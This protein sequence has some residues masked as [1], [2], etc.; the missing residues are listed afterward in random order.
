MSTTNNER[1]KKSFEKYARP[2]ITIDKAKNEQYKTFVKSKG[3]AS[4]N[5]YFNAVITYD[6]EHNIIPHKQDLNSP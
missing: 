5:D 2:T 6:I 4:L 1:V 3:Y